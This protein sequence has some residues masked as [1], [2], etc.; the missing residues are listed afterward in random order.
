VITLALTIPLLP[1]AI[2]PFLVSLFIVLM[3][4]GGLG[5][6]RTRSFAR[7]VERV[8]GR[9]GLYC[10]IIRQRDLFFAALRRGARVESVGP[11]LAL[12]LASHLV[13]TLSVLVLV[14]DSVGGGL[15]EALFLGFIALEVSHVMVPLRPGARACSSTG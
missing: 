4:V 12:T 7:V 14:W 5:W 2:L 11:A 13:E 15:P 10:Y 6:A 3:W 1:D 9:R 8:A